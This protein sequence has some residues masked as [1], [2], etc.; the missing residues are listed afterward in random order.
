MQLGDARSAYETLSGKVSD[1]V[2]QMSLAGIALVWLF[3]TT[4]AGSG[5]IVV[6]NAELLRAALFVTLALTF[7][8]LQYLT[9]TITWFL[10]FRHKEKQ[11]TSEKHEFQAP[12]QLNWPTWTLFYLKCA[13]M[14]VAYVA[15]ILPFLVAKFFSN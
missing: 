4:P 6:I 10:Y 12:A 7:D 1:I 5:G 11:G 8:F 14:L 15:Y 13:A 3:R 2:R 9:G